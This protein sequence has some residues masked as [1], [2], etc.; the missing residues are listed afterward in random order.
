[1]SQ[2][3]AGWRERMDSLVA[4]AVARSRN[5]DEIL[6]D[7]TALEAIVPFYRRAFGDEPALLIADENTWGA[8][9]AAIQARLSEA[10]I[11]VE[12]HLL[13]AEPRPKASLDLAEALRERIADGQAHPVAVGSGV[14]NDLVKYAAFQLERPY[15]CVATAASMDGY[16]SAGAPLS[17]RGFKKTVTC[18][19]PKA[20]LADLSVITAAPPEMVGWGF[21]DLAGKVP[22]GG[23]WMLADAL[24][25]EPLDD[26]AWPL[27][28]DNLRGWLAA[29]AALAA[30]DPAATA[31]LFVG[32]TLS[33]LA[34]EFHGTSRPAS[35][36]DH[37]VAHL[38]EM[39]GLTHEGQRVSHGACVS[40]G[41][42]AVLRLYDWLL[43]QDLAALDV[44]ACVAAHPDME[45][46][47]QLIEESFDS[48]D[49]AERAKLE[50]A[51]KHLDPEALAA[52]LMHLQAIWPSLKAR[53]SSHLMRADEM[54]HLLTTAGA[55]TR[56]AD[57]GVGAEELCATVLAARFMR[58]RYTLLDLL[59][60]TGL[61]ADALGTVFSAEQS[62]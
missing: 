46:K 18:A 54:Q 7:E 23:D 62:I 39:R 28:Q 29:P 22:A 41:C 10:D 49:I 25:I 36:A 59:D 19:P 33:G 56:A 17:D 14:I 26:V 52:R 8:A 32:L 47:A 20:I 15:L 53:L 4:P 40:V 6:V 27:V 30:G 1:M 44:A 31:D 61:L 42:L 16:A 51:S 5:I 2:V 50:T 9:G 60:E 3:I 43:A 37:Q 35:G 12:G 38:W 34:M 21:G 13:P 11:A 24:G 48:P 55:P 45:S 58:S 57:I